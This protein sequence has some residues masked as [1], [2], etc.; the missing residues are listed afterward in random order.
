MLNNKK[1]IVDIEEKRYKRRIT[2]SSDKELSY[3]M[4]PYN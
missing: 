3:E 4:N 2:K 1:I